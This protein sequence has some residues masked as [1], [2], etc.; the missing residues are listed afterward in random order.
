M[1]CMFV[2]SL[3]ILLCCPG[4]L[5]AHPILLYYTQSTL[6]MSQLLPSAL[7][8]AL[9]WGSILTKYVWTYVRT[10]W[11]TLRNVT[12]NVDTYHRYRPYVRHTV[13]HILDSDRRAN[14][15]VL[16]RWKWRSGTAGPSRLGYYWH[17]TV[18]PRPTTNIT[19]VMR[20]SPVPAYDACTSLRTGVRQRCT[21]IF[22]V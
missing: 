13:W 12:R 1:W 19:W 22:L 8:W 4:D 3:S 18:S 10:W 9:N 17:Q 21:S 7:E 2:T 11:V 20:T 14:D 15:S 6:Q 5:H 16:W